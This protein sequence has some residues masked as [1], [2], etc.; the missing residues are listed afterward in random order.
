[1][2]KKNTDSTKACIKCGSKNVIMI[3]KGLEIDMYRCK[4]CGEEY[5]VT[6]LL[7]M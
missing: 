3:H 6:D 7:R 5:G 1:M 2:K 4:D